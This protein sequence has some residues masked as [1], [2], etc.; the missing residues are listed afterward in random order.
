[1]DKKS[2]INGHVGPTSKEKKKKIKKKKRHMRQTME[3]RI[4]RDNL[5]Y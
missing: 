2:G 4:S 3:E 1:M 5:F